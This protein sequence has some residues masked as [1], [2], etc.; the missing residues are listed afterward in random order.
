MCGSIRNEI[1]QTHFLSKLYHSTFFRIAVYGSTT[2]FCCLS[3][4]LLWRPKNKSVYHGIYLFSISF[5]T[6]QC[7]LF[8]PFL[9][10]IDKISFLYSLYKNMYFQQF[11]VTLNYYFPTYWFVIYHFNLLLPLSFLCYIHNMNFIDNTIM[12]YW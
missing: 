7:C 9:A 3:I 5:E 4:Y 6:L 12:R 8:S 2:W 10:V 11:Y 1:E